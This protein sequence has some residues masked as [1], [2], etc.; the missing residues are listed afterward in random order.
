MAPVPNAGPFG[1]NGKTVEAEIV[2]GQRQTAHLSNDLFGSVT[3]TTDI[4]WREFETLGE[5]A[6]RQRLA[7]RIWDEEKEAL[8]RQW[9]KFRDSSEAADSRRKTIDVA[10]EANELAVAANESAREAN[11]VARDAANSARESAAAARTNNKIATLAL[12]AAVIAIV[13]SIIPIIA[14]FLK[15]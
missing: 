4:R 7:G 12:I 2:R 3:E 10:R 9:L 11:A 15:R 5:E 14:A 6:V 1:G 13:V 8:A